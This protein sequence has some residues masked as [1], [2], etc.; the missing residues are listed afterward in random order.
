[1]KYFDWDD[2]R[3]AK[4]RTERGIGFEEIV[5]HIER[6]DPL[7]ILEHSNPER[8]GGQ[9]IFVLRRE[10]YVYLVPFP[11]SPPIGEACYGEVSPKRFARRRTSRISTRCC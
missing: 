2:A 3:N 9:R 4:L 1:M 7:D 11:P 6:G 10:D 8:Y 5:F